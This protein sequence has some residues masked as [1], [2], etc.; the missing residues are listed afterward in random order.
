MTAANFNEIWTSRIGAEGAAE[1]RR[2]GYLT[3]ALGP[4][5]LGLAVVCSF[6]F[7]SGSW[8]GVTLGCVALFAIA[9][10]GAIW[11]RSR[12][13]FVAAMSRWFGV[14]IG[15]MEVPRMRP[16]QFDA[17]C[18]RRNLQRPSAR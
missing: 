5:I 2:S 12:L 11:M 9:A 15:W 10:M 8:T 7:G 6:G 3:L 16:D 18:R 4:A 13:R 1:L 17:W 14:K